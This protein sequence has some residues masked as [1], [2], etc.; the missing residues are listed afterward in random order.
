MNYS[1]TFLYNVPFVVL[2]AELFD[3]SSGTQLPFLLF[4]F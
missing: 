3:W 2:G 4:R 1:P